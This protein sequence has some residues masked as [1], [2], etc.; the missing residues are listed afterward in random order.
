MSRVDNL[1]LS[2]SMGGGDIA[3]DSEFEVAFDILE[4]LD[5]KDP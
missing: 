1:G 3:L 4:A 5:F 2:P